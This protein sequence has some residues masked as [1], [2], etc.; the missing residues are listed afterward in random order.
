MLK[1]HQNQ[2]LIGMLIISI[3]KYF[4]FLNNK[5]SSKRIINGKELTNKDGVQIE[6]DVNNNKYTLNI[7]KA[8]PAIHSGT[9]IIKASNIIGSIQHELALNILGMSIIFL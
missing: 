4:L 2:Q 8:N 7:P 5:N 3:I 9:L 6:K 1:Q